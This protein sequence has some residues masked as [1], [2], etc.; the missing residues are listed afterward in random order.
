MLASVPPFYG[1][2]FFILSFTGFVLDIISCHQAWKGA[3]LLIL[4]QKP[5]VSHVSRQV[6]NR[7]CKKQGLAESC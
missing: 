4:S 2:A 6:C 1:Q 3:S 7:A 5:Q